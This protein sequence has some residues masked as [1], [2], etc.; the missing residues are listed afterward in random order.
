VDVV[1]GL[2]RE[3]VR[4]AFERELREAP[5]GGDQPDVDE[6]F[7]FVLPQ[8]GNEVRKRLSRMPDGVNG[9]GRIPGR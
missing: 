3:R 6:P 1:D 7:D 5:R 9:Q 4:E 2:F 8:Q